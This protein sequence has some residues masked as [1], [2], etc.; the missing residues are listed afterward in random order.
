MLQENEMQ[1]EGT[2]KV[3]LV[4]GEC[5]CFKQVDQGRQGPLKRAVYAES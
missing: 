4:A 1:G 3:Q 5:G 2:K